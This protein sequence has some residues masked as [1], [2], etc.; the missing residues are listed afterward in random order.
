MR[1]K[2]REFNSNQTQNLRKVNIEEE[3][4]EKIQKYKIITCLK[5]LNHNKRQL[6]YD[7]KLRNAIKRPPKIMFVFS[8]FSPFACSLARE[9]RCH[10]QLT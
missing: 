7:V 1:R 2:R 5:A 9:H 10:F 4:R 8:S 3:E 6:K